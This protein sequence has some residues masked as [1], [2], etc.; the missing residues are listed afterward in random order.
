LTIT[1]S[2]GNKQPFGQPKLA[3]CKKRE[4]QPPRADDLIAP[5]SARDRA[6]GDRNERGLGRVQRPDRIECLLVGGALRGGDERHRIIGQAPRAQQSE[7]DRQAQRTG[8]NHVLRSHSRQR[9]DQRRPVEG[10]SVAPNVV[11]SH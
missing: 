3:R 10:Q 4:E 9:R 1:P 6:V 5:R 8:L 11:Q 7:V 2:A